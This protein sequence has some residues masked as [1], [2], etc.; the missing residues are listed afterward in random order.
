MCSCRGAGLSPSP[1]Q[2]AFLGKPKLQRYLPSIIGDEL[3]IHPSLAPYDR[4]MCVTAP[5]LLK[6]E[7]QRASE[8]FLAL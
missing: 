1:H 3:V 6:A 2:G 8:R 4:I 5:W 7:F